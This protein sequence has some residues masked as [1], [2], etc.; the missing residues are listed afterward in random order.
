[1][2]W[3]VLGLMGGWRGVGRSAW[4]LYHCLGISSSLR[5]TLNSF[6]VSSFILKKN[7]LKFQF[8]ITIICLIVKEYFTKKYSS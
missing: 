6:I 2:G 8:Q 5:K 3:A 7:A 4:M 1:M